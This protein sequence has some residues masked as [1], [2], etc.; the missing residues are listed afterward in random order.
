MLKIVRVCPSS[1]HTYA[2]TINDGDIRHRAETII[3]HADHGIGQQVKMPHP[4]NN[5]G[6]CNL[7]SRCYVAT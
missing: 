6:V 4:A 7:S 2:L 1:G 5:Y 3:S